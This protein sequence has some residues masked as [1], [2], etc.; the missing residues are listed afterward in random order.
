MRRTCR[1]AP[2]DHP[3]VRSRRTRNVAGVNTPRA[4]KSLRAPKLHASDG[5]PSRW[6]A[7]PS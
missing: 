5:R 1:A 2:D 6:F 7:A 4:S 3:N